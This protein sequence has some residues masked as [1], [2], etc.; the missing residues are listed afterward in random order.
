MPAPLD[1]F[2]C[3]P[4][5]ARSPRTLVQQYYEF[6]ELSG[7]HDEGIKVLCAEVRNTFSEL[8]DLCDKIF[9]IPAALMPRE[10]VDLSSVGKQA[11][12]SEQI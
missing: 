2:I 7:S 4:V 8:H 6:S 10:C 3:T 1:V 11:T 9:C 12:C 5:S